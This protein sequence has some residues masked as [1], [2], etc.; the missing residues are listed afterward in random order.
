MRVCFLLV[1]C[2]P[3]QFILNSWLTTDVSMIWWSLK[4]CTNGFS[5]SKLNLIIL[6]IS[7]SEVWTS[8]KI[9]KNNFKNH[10]CMSRIYPRHPGLHR[11][12]IHIKSCKNC[13]VIH[14][15]GSFDGK[16]M[17]QLPKISIGVYFNV[18]RPTLG[19]FANKQRKIS[20][21]AAASNQSSRTFILSLLLLLL[22]VI[23]SDYQ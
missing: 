3:W 12:R 6:P 21:H 1:Q 9:C 7:S 14:H 20:R 17:L 8:E 22:R 4:Q 18:K 2:S 11:A 16:G 10:L 19:F 23:S 13:E 15:K 5:I